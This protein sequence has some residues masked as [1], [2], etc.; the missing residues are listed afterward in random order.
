MNS[1]Q[2]SSS[3]NE[4]DDESE[5]VEDM[6]SNQTNGVKKSRGPEYEK[7][8]DCGICG[9]TLLNKSHLKRHEKLHLGQ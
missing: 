6:R 3:F 8:V 9:K 5:H 1:D 4:S 2:E 7:K